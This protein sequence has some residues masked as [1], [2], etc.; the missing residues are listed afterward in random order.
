MTGTANDLVD[1]LERYMAEMLH[2]AN[3]ASAAARN[4]WLFFLALTAYYF[5]ALAGVSHKDLLLETPIEL[6]LLQVKIP[7]R[8]FFLFGPLI[9]VLVHFGL[10]LQHVMLARKL[11]EFHSRVSHHEGKELFRQHRFRVQL[12]SYTYSQAVAGPKRSPLLG[13]FLHAMTWITLGL[14]P[15]IVLLDFQTTYLPYHDAGVTNMHRFYVVLDFLV[16][17][18]F[19]VFLRFP[20]K[21]FGAGFAANLTQHPGNFFVTLIVAFAALVFSFLIA[22]FPGEPLDQIAQSLWPAPVPYGK[23]V[24][25]AKR[26]AFWPTAYLF[27]G[28]TDDIQG[29]PNSLFSRNL[30]VINTAVVPYQ[31]PDPDDISISLRGR[32]LKYASL[33]RSDLRR[34]DLTGADLTSASL[35][36]TNLI[37]AR[38]IKA[39]IR[40][41]DMRHALLVSVNLRGAELEG[42]K[43][44]A[45]QKGLIVFGNDN[46]INQFVK[47]PCGN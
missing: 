29:R 30:V 39:N 22:T 10:L 43:I 2:D 44:C 45:E 38:L 34:A 20:E 41:A 13:A 37:K 6:P 27:E 9:L 3:V 40:N 19:G 4:A 16:L 33:D 36:Q 14:L 25:Q 31:Q 1:R 5:V 15:L 12:H 11:R 28:E 23:A 21:G 8:S 47:E 24:D 26:T 17:L 7:Q 32:D 35:V 42:A 46:A 18:V